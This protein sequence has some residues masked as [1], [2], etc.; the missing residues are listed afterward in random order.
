[1]EEKQKKII[2]QGGNFIRLITCHSVFLIRVSLQ[3][4]NRASHM[5]NIF[6]TDCVTF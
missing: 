3:K 5:A 4:D 6:Y 1:M 2:L